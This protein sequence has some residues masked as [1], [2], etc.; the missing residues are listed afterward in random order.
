MTNLTNNNVKTDKELLAEAMETI[1]ALS[2][3]L[4]KEET[5]STLDI[6]V[7][8]AEEKARLEVRTEANN[9]FAMRVVAVFIGAVA[10]WTILDLAIFSLTH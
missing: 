5:I 6:D 10:V 9:K 2:K 7:V 8:K 1:S 4:D 3:R